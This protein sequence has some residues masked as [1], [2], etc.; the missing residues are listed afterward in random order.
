MENNKHSIFSPSSLSRYNKCPGSGYLEIKLK[1]TNF[2]INETN[3]ASIEGTRKHEVAYDLISGKIKH[4]DVV[5][6]DVKKYYDFLLKV[7]DG[8]LNKLNLEER[9]QFIVDNCYT[10]FGT[11]DAYFVENNIINLIDFKSG[12]VRVNANNNLQLLTYA[13][14][15]YSNYADLDNIKRINLY[16]V[17]PTQKYSTYTMSYVDFFSIDI[18]TFKSNV[19]PIILETT[20]N[21]FNF[22]GEFNP[23]VENCKYC[24]A[25]FICKAREKKATEAYERFIKD[26]TDFS[27]TNNGDITNGYI[28]RY[29]EDLKT[30]EDFFSSKRKHI[31]NLL[32]EDG[33]Q[34]YNFIITP[35]EKRKYTKEAE[36][37]L[38]EQLGESAFKTKKS[39][40]TVTELNKINKEL[41]NK[42][43]QKELSHYDIKKR[44]T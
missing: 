13:Y 29:L 38:F 14:A 5:E 37:I 27:Y 39:L 6:E 4:E 40:I 19:I 3:N 31:E 10:G 33:E 41:C 11:A 25:R 18:D 26:E 20:K 30:T 28:E 36:N 43:T 22:N 21:I 34:K 42:V 7:T 17:Q 32:L 23:S 8:D 9:V 16:I 1:D 15:V 2:I 12:F 44:I 24:K 35:I